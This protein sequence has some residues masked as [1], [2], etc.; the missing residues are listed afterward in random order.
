MKGTE[1]PLLDP[2][3]MCPTVQEACCT[4]SDQ[5]AMVER[6]LKKS[7]K[8]NLTDRLAFHKRVFDRNLDLIQEIAS[9][10]KNLRMKLETEPNSNCKLLVTRIGHFDLEHVIPQVK[11]ALEN[12]HNFFMKTYEGIYCTLCN[13]ENHKFFDVQNKK[14]RFSNKFC[15]DIVD[16]SLHFLLY[17]HNHIPKLNNIL[18]RY[19]VSCSNGGV[20]TE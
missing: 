19:V 2:V 10:A 7:E 5:Y 6:W 4:V 18:S 9:R 11:I 3:D 12:L 1:K 20:F 13:A 15:R 16:H 14:I 17:F 8:N